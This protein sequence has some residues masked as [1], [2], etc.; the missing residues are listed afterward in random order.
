M[1]GAQPMCRKQT[2]GVRMNQAGPLLKALRVIHHRPATTTVAKLRAEVCHGDQADTARLI[3]DLKLQGWA[4]VH[5]SDDGRVV[6]LTEAGERQAK[7]VVVPEFDDSR[8]D[9]EVVQKRARKAYKTRQA[10]KVRTDMPSCDHPG[11]LVWVD[12]ARHGWTT[13]PQVKARTDNPESTV[14][15][16]RLHEQGYLRRWPAGPRRYFWA[17]HRPHGGLDVEVSG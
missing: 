3:R 4:E 5:P 16:H 13:A 9:P 8:E 10:G 11:Y 15:I 17:T 7:G 14:L 12:I 2:D 1:I 6:L